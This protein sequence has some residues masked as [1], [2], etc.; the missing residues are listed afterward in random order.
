MSIAIQLEPSVEKKLEALSAKAG[1]TKTDYLHDAIVRAIEDIED[2][3]AA[4]AAYESWHSGK[5]RTFAL[6]EV[7][8]DLGLDD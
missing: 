7:R 3:Y 2:V 5:E 4:D 1:K 6:Q 8:R